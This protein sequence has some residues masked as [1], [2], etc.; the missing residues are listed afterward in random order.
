M[1][2]RRFAWRAIPALLLV[3]MASLVPAQG[4]KAQAATPSVVSQALAFMPETATVA[5]FTDWA[6][7]KQYKGATA[8]TNASPLSAKQ[9]FLNSLLKDQAVTA[10]FGL[11]FYQQMSGLWSFDSLDLQWEAE[12]DTTDTPVSV[13]RFNDSFNF[14]P[15][16]AHFAQRKYARTVYRG[17]ALYSHPMDV[18]RKWFTQG[19]LGVLNAAYLPTLHIIVFSSATVSVKGALDAYLGRSPSL[20]P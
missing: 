13:L 7:I 19:P 11:E 8:L 4:G 16:L 18:T 14:A 12:A 1:M 5:S 9:K 15:L 3:C 10:Q 20:A 6:L 17:I 2:I